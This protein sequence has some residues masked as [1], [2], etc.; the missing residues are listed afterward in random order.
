LH[1]K[2]DVSERFRAV[3]AVRIFAITNDQD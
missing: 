3:A 2:R 1:A